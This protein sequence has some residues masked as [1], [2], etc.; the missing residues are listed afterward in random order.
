MEYTT[1]QPW[2]EISEQGIVY[3]LGSLYD[4]F[5]QISDPRKAKGKQY[6]LLTL[7][8]LIFL[9]KLA[10]KD[11]PMEIAD[12]AKNH[13]EE[14]AELLGLDR[15]QMPHHNTYRRVF[16]WILSVE[17]FEALLEEYHQQHAEGAG[18][19]LCVDGKVMRGT[20]KG[21][22]RSGEQVLSIYDG[23]SQQVKAQVMIA[24]KE[25]EIVA[26]PL[27]TQ[28]VDVAGKV[29]TADALHTQREWCQQIVTGQGDYVLPVKENQ[30]RLYQD[31]ERLFAP[32]QPKPGFGKIDTDFRSA[33]QVSYGHGRLEIRTI[34]TSELLNDYS[35]WPGLGQV[36]RLERRFFW[37]RQGQVYQSSTA[38][39]FGITSLSRQQAD[40]KRVLSLRR[41]QWQIETGLHYRRDVT[42]HEDATR[43]TVG[44]APAILS[45]V[46]NLVLGLLKTA[47]FSNAAAGRRYF[48][49]HLK[50][51]F[52]LLL[53][54]VPLS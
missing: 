8:I 12:W 45:I 15:K 34:Q 50:Q 39:E 25:N 27:L 23:T 35:D 7:L 37:L 17:E 38:V 6:S 11:K 21:G 19:V 43:M 2:E 51:A 14:L 31:I 47:G 54:P 32:D 29:V 53:S 49:G 41:H 13:R 22:E 10:G 5:Q 42:F 18:E 26:A 48:E 33:K 3:T 30:P 44:N 40:P 1:L 24:N 4:R 20:R 52:A 9:A 36:Y 28:Q 46:H 16:Q